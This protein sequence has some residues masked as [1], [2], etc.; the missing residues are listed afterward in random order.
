MESI[1]K[2]EEDKLKDLKFEIDNLGLRIEG[3]AVGV[4]KDKMIEEYNQKV[5]QY[6]ILFKSYENVYS[7]YTKLFDEYQQDI[8]TYN[9]LLDSYNTG[10]IPAV[11][12]NRL[13]EEETSGKIYVVEVGDSLGKIAQKFGTTIE[14]IITRNKL[15]NPNLIRPGQKLIIPTE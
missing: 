8:I 15:A 7:E 6:N 2:A 1:F 3:T 11:I 12:Q 4:G 13:S 10:T 5:E 9:S 14:S